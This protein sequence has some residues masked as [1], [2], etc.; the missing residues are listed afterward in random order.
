MNSM[1]TSGPRENF[2]EKIDKGELIVPPLNEAVRLIFRA[3]THE[4]I[5]KSGKKRNDEFITF[6]FV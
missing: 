1:I 5:T 4:Q 3:S 2:H 6:R